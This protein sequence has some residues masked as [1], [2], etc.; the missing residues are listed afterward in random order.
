VINLL[1]DFDTKHLLHCFG[2]YIFGEQA[3]TTLCSLLLLVVEDIPH[4]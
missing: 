2:V 1:A 4:M 3:T